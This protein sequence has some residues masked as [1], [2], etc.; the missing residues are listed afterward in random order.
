MSLSWSPGIRLGQRQRAG[1]RLCFLVPALPGWVSVLIVFPT[2]DLL[3][4]QREKPLDPS[5][6]LEP[7]QFK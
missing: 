3:D 5:T 6:T 7:T 1:R 4:A 2:R